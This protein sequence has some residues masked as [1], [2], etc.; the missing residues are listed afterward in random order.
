MFPQPIGILGVIGISRGS[1][2]IWGCEPADAG[3]HPQI[4]GFTTAIP[5]E[6]ILDMYSEAWYKC[7]GTTIH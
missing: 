2:R 6:P 1:I 5:K 4:R 7:T 3:S